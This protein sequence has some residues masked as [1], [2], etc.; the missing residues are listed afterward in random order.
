MKRALLSLL[1]VSAAGCD[2]AGT[3]SIP[4]TTELASE[5]VL[6]SGRA[7]VSTERGFIVAWAEIRP[8]PDGPQILW[9]EVDPD[10]EITRGPEVV[11]SIGRRSPRLR[12]IEVPGGYQLWY[13]AGRSSPEALV[14]STDGEV[15]GEVDPDISNIDSG[16]GIFDVASLGDAV[17]LFWRDTGDDVNVQVIDAAGTPR[18][19]A[20]DLGD[21]TGPQVLAFDDHFALFWLDD[22][23]IQRAT[24]DTSGAMLLEREAIEPSSSGWDLAARRVG[25]GVFF[26]WTFRASPGQGTRHLYWTPDGTGWSEF[27][28]LIAPNRAESNSHYVGSADGRVLVAVQSDAERAIPQLVFAEV[29]L[30]SMG[31]LGE[32]RELTPPGVFGGAVAFAEGPSGVGLVFTARIE[33]A[34]RM[35]FRLLP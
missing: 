33:G 27:R 2:G 16:Q 18:A 1:L 25:D 32:F 31:L 23:R 22:G 7:I 29:D 28:E 26:G 15:L 6:R 30:G 12:F 10:G 3:S 9:T 24:V 4:G 19:D 17:A 21:G 5:P 11:A 35:F 13:W 20:I 34:T 8:E 14:F